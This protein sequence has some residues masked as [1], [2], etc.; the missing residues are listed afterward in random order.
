MSTSDCIQL[1]SLKEAFY[2]PQS[3]NNIS[4]ISDKTKSVTFKLQEK[5][6]SVD[7]VTVSASSYQTI[8]TVD[9]EVASE[10]LRNSGTA[11]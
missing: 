5:V 2:E 9:A 6:V 4:L 11:G 7:A 1:K 10:L 3:L 8:N